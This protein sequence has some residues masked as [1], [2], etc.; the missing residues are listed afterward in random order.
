MNSILLIDLSVAGLRCSDNE[1]K[2]IASAL[3]TLVRYHNRKLTTQSANADIDSAA[4]ALLETID[5]T[6][7]HGKGQ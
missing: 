5:A 2:G 7:S 3:V 4:V 6:E 1:L